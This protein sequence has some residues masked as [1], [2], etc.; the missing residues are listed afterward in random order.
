ML[1]NKDT[2]KAINPLV[3]LFILILQ[4]NCSQQLSHSWISPI[5]YHHVLIRFQNDSISVFGGSRAQ[6]WVFGVERILPEE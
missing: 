1:E 2:P 4:Q 5:Q 3:I 6:M